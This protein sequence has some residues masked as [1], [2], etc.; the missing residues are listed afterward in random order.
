MRFAL[1]LLLA[2]AASV[3]AQAP[4][5]QLEAPAPTPAVQP[6]AADAG[7]GV[8]HALNNAFARVFDMVAPSVVIIEATKK[9]EGTGNPALDDLFFNNQGDDAP[10]RNRERQSQS[11]GSG[12]IVRGDGHIFTNYHVVDGA[13]RIDV[14]LKDGR[15]FQ[16]KLIGADE[17]TDVAVIKIEA[18]NLPA[19]QI[20]DSEAV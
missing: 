3:Q 9:N 2:L 1:V 18:N 4:A 14:K 7:K 6:E 8:V 20:G 16:A 10:R 19:V 17:K 13:D 12:F 5:A 15:E 11:E